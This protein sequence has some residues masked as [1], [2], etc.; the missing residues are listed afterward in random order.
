MRQGSWLSERRERCV[1]TRRKQCLSGCY[2]VWAQAARRSWPISREVLRDAIIPSPAR[3]R[4]TDTRQT[5]RQRC[6]ENYILHYRKRLG[7]PFSNVSR[8]IICQSKGELKGLSNRPRGAA[9]LFSIDYSGLAA[10]PTM[11]CGSLH[12]RYNVAH[13]SRV[14]NDEEITVIIYG[15]LCPLTSKEIAR[16]RGKS[17]FHR[18]TRFV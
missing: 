6:N 16:Q 14:I 15:C 1:R 7:R 9:A 13:A 2:R 5:V 12:F 3:A 18:W 4:T 11:F 10:P 8:V 17:Q